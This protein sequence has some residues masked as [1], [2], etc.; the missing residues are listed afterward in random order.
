MCF[1]ASVALC[2]IGARE[3]GVWSPG[4]SHV[5]VYGPSR[6]G[7]DSRASWSHMLELFA[8]SLVNCGLWMFVKV[9]ICFDK[10]V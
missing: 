1:R 5:G 8:E 4:I 2:C 9:L 10:Y 3:L 7:G 6:I